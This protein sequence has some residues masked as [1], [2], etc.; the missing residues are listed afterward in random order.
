MKTVPVLT[1]IDSPPA[2]KPARAIARFRRYRNLRDRTAIGRSSCGL[3]DLLTIGL[4]SA[5][6]ASVVTALSKGSSV[7]MIGN[8]ADYLPPERLT[9][10]RP[11]VFFDDNL[12]AHLRD[13]R[14]QTKFA[15]N[16]TRPSLD[17]FFAG[18]K[19]CSDFTPLKDLWEPVCG[20]VRLLLLVVADLPET[21]YSNQIARILEVESLVKRARYGETPCIRTDGMVIVPGWIDQRRE[22]RFTVNISVICNFSKKRVRVVLKDLSITA[23]GLCSCPTVPVGTAIAIELPNARILDGRVIWS[24]GTNI[25]VRFDKPLADQDPIFKEFMEIRQRS[26]QIILG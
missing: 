16:L 22:P 9:D 3:A 8:P 20:Q 21:R 6:I 18:M 12:A 1:A 2:Q 13:I 14:R 19:T 10:E 4:L 7:R 17:D 25:G 26:D 23:A 24:Q 5:V 11:E 15:A